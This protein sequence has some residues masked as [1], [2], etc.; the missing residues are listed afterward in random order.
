M[1][2]RPKQMIDIEM[3]VSENVFER[4]KLHLSQSLQ[5]LHIKV[6]DVS[7]DSIALCP[8]LHPLL[9]GC[10]Y[11]VESHLLQYFEILPYKR[12]FKAQ[13]AAALI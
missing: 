13:T 4:Q 1:Q 6:L 9:L 3:L 12:L 5:V 8:V 10:D 11:V 2:S 7:K